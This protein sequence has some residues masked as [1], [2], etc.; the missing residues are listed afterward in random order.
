M[1][2]ETYW[3]ARLLR[4]WLCSW[5]SSSSPSQL[6]FNKQLKNKKYSVNYLS[7]N[8]LYTPPPVSFGPMGTPVTSTHCT[9]DNY[10]PMF[11]CRLLCI[12][13]LLR[14]R[15]ILPLLLLGMLGKSTARG[16]GFLGVVR[17][18]PTTGWLRR[19]LGVLLCPDN[20]GDP[21]LRERTVSGWGQACACGGVP[22]GSKAGLEER[23]HC[24][25]LLWIEERKRGGGMANVEN[26]L[27][28]LF[29]ETRSVQEQGKWGDKYYV[30]IAVASGVVD[31]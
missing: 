6:L 10:C 1:E 22:W 14:G 3:R 19:R 21:W 30:T 23:R 12:I 17:C 5:L 18:Q 9:R 2:D 27:F 26:H 29:R 4:R 7:S 24:W 8:A 11:F 15:E 31:Q 28:S 13:T 16:K 25:F 20:V